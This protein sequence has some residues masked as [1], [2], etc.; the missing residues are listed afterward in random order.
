MYI[1]NNSGS[2]GFQPTSNASQT[3]LYAIKLRPYFNISRL[4]QQ[5]GFYI[6]KYMPIY[7]IQQQKVD[8]RYERG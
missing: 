5:S 4:L 8:I 7:L 3:L 6:H 2:V 1:C